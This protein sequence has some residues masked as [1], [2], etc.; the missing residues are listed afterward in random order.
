[1]KK[2]ILSLV[3]ASQALTN[4]K[5]KVFFGSV[6]EM[7]GNEARSV[8]FLHPGKKFNE[9]HEATKRTFTRDSLNV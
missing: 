4:C 3:F 1:M 6:A 9:V 8:L 2:F 5:C 7:K